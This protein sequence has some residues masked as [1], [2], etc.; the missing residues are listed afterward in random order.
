MG[1]SPAAPALGYHEAAEDQP[2][3]YLLWDQF[4]LV[5]RQAAGSPVPREVVNWRRSASR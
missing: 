4:G 5:A 1:W 3:P 2:P